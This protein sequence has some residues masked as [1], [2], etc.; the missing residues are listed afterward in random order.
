MFWVRRGGIYQVNIRL[1][2]WHKIFTICLSNYNWKHL[3]RRSWL[4]LHKKWPKQCRSVSVSWDSCSQFFLNVSK[5]LMWNMVVSFNICYFTLIFCFKRVDLF[6]HFSTI[7]ISKLSIDALSRSSLIW[8][9]AIVGH[10]FLGLRK[11]YI[12]GHFFFPSNFPHV[13]E[14]CFESCVAI[15]NNVNIFCKY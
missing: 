6:L 2:T 10:V 3:E 9:S 13:A 11:V 12:Y 1:L 5:P 8:G 4:A 7:H 15:W 14:L